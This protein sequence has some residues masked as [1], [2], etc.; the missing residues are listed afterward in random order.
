MIMS[1]I[2]FPLKNFPIHLF[3]VK[4]TF[5]LVFFLRQRTNKTVQYKNCTGHSKDILYTAK[6][7]LY[8]N[9]RVL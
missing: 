7:N 5:T 4:H 8:L 1:I 9:D 2:L 6:D 3:K